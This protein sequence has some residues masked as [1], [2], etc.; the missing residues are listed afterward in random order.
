MRDLLGRLDIK[1]L[2][3]DKYIDSLKSNLSSLPNIG[4]AV[5]GGGYRAMTNGAG[6]LEAFDDRTPNSTS[7]GQLGGLLQSAT[8]LS[9][10]SGGNWLVGSLYTNNFTSI[11]T[12][13]AQDSADADSGDLWQLGNSIF[14]GPDTGGIQLLDSVG[15]YN[16][17][18][19][20]VTAKKNAGFNITIT[21]YWGRALSFQLVN[22][23]N[24]G[25]DYTFSSIAKQDWFT[26]GSVPLPFIITDGRRPGETI[27][28]SNG[29]VY[30]FNPWEFGTEDS[31]VYG[32][33]PLQYI[34]TNF[35]GGSPKTDKCVTGFDNV[36][37]VMGTSST[38]FN[39]AIAG[40]SPV[41]TQGWPKILQSAISGV[42]DAV[43]ATNV[44]IADY[45]NPFYNYRSG[46]NRIAGDAEL[47]L[48][49][50]GEDGQNIPFHPLIQTYRWV[51]LI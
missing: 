8:Y 25:P 6:V 23:T 4:I 18:Y 34:G 49:D 27:V 16:T 42:L 30:N 45:P 31:T 44:D 19:D 12:I 11:N 26:S 47:T 41:V 46:S 24:G 37:F 35:S 33:V 43:G 38:I 15:Y 13:L 3:T 7:K 39:A 40:I 48:V 9:A 1:G 28:S 14:E 21:D 36:G 5:S 51:N 22:A 50:G 10:L 32:F 17:L 2:D 20:D 29:T